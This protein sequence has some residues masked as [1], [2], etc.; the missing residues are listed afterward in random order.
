MEEAGRELGGTRGMKT[1][2]DTK[3]WHE[4]TGET[5]T[6]RERLVVGG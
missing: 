2:D 4:D 6:K 1:R 3:P 5:G